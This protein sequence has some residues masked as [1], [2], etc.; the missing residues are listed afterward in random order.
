MAM[1]AGRMAARQKA[2][3][4]EGRG[5][6]SRQSR[7]TVAVF[8]HNSY[9]TEKDRLQSFS[10]RSCCPWRWL[11]QVAASQQCC[12]ATPPYRRD[13]SSGSWWAAIATATYSCD[14][15]MVVLVFGWR[16]AGGGTARPSTALGGVGKSYASLAFPPIFRAGWGWGCGWLGPPLSLVLDNAWVGA[17]GK[18]QP[19]QMTNHTILRPQ[20]MFPGPFILH[21]SPNPHL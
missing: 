2:A 13:A 3:A 5:R 10:T 21:F 6:P 4:S 20:L 19:L 8:L 1:A 17:G 15:T 16:K 14:R 18:G 11:A 7:P 9:T 12:T